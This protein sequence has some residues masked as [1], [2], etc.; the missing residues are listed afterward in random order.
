MCVSREVGAP[1]SAGDD[2]LRLVVDEVLESRRY[3]WL[4]RDFVTRIA[5]DAVKRTRRPSDA[6]KETKRRLHQAFGAYVDTLRADR[7]ITSLQRAAAQG[8]AALRR[9]A[10]EL[11]AEHASTRERLPVLDAFFADVF[12]VTGRPTTVLDLACGLGTLALPWLDLPP[13]GVYH[14]CDVDQRFVHIAHAALAAFGVEGSATLCDV[15]AQAPETRAD[16]ALLLKAVPCLEQ[17]A[18]G[19]AARLLDA[20]QARWLVVSFP[21]RSLGGAA[22]GMV[23]HYREVMAALLSARGWQAQ[24]LLF[25]RELAFVVEAGR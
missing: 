17:Q 19:S 14:A 5:S 13:G 8:D 24:E 25:P 2:S 16:V 23:S 7:V 22:K 20:V 1:P 21:T 6:V 18:P 4:A 15:A 10:Q 12:A 9:T 3:R 11:M